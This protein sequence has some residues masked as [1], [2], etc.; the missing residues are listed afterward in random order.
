LNILQIHNKIPFP[1]KDGGSV[2]VYSLSKSFAM[3]GHNV[4][5]LA[6]NTNKH[7][8]DLEKYIELLPANLNVYP[9]DINTDI[10]PFKAI[11]NLLF[12]KLPYNAERFISK[13][14]Q[15]RL[16]QILNKIEYDLIQIEGLYMMP[17]LPSIK[18]YSKSLVS[19][20]AHNI[21]NEI[22]LN[23]AS[24]GKNRIKKIYSKILF[25]RIKRLELSLINRYDLLIPITYKDADYFLKA[26]NTKPMHV[27]PTGLEIS[28]YHPTYKTINKYDFFHL[29]SLDWIPNQEGLL[30]FLNN[31]WSVVTKH[32]KNTVFT[33]CGRN[34]PDSF[35]CKLKGFE[36][37]IYEGEIDDALEFLK[38]QSIMIVPLFSGSGMRI[39]IIEG[40]A[41]GNIII[42]TSK[43]LEGIPAQH[44][45]HLLVA[46]TPGDFIESVEKIISEVYQLHEISDNAQQFI[47]DN[48]D[49]FALTNALLSFY[50]KAID[51]NKK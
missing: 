15:N 28:N 35:I 2:A 4:D 25:K 19:F 21:E 46:D 50:Q 27:S 5:I 47:S 9:V 24:L 8:V 22:W 20:R 45:K 3:L 14:F 26:G 6:L 32:H 38:T 31:V 16:I 13:R 41:A 43:G 51:A 7:H 39:K 23:N 44:G 17:Y 40:L 48:F 11:I 29:G 42:T 49:N 36:N 34:A 30:W 12:S 33:I 18:K 10:K 1:P 37:V